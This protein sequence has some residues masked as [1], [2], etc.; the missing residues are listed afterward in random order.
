MQQRSG[1]GSILQLVNRMA[2]LEDCT[3]LVVEL[4]VDVEEPFKGMSWGLLYFT[5][6]TFRLVPSFCSCAEGL[7]F[8]ICKW[9]FISTICLRPGN[10]AGLSYVPY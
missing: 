10:L 7:S 3:E 4:A 8:G 5:Q 2:A 6:I 9:H 1:T